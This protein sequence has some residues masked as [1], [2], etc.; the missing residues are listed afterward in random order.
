MPTTSSTYD[1]IFDATAG[2]RRLKVLTVLDEYTRLVLAIVPGR[3]LTSATAKGMLAKLFVR[4]GRPQV[5]RSACCHAL[6]NHALRRLRWPLL[7]QSS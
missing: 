4:H 1:F 5:I 6:V 7:V 2:G 3:S